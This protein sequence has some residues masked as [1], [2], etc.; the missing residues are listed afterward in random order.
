[1]VPQDAIRSTRVVTNTYD[2]ARGQFSGG[3]VASTTR[4]GTNVPQGAFTYSGRDRAL[5][6]GGVTASPFS[7]GYTQNQIGGGMGGP[8]VRDQLFAFAALQG[9]W[10]DQALPSLVTADPATLQRLGVSSDSA[11][12]L[13]A[14]AG[15]ARAPPNLPPGPNNPRAHNTTAPLR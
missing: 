3:L 12:R 4:S 10:K 7:Q 8:I 13:V 2:V 11:A 1:M 15:A 6:W 9:C 5:A 14:L